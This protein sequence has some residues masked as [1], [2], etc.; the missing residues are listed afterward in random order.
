MKSFDYYLAN[1]LEHKIAQ[2]EHKEPRQETV[3]FLEDAKKII[4]KFRLK[5]TR[6][7]DL[8]DELNEIIMD[9]L[10]V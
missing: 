5:N 2:H 3:L 1:S 9:R 7:D 4:N 8:L 6:A 10:N